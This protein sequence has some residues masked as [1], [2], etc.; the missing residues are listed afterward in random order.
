MWVRLAGGTNGGGVRGG[1][2]NSVTGPQF[3]SSDSHSLQ[4]SLE[5]QP[6]LLTPDKGH[7][8]T[9]LG[10]HLVTGLLCH[11]PPPRPHG[12]L[13]DTHTHTLTRS[14]IEDTSVT[15]TPLPFLHNLQ[16]AQ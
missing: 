7:E 8:F 2:V 10:Y 3:M 5:T 14:L 11:P 15:Q 13:S 16:T 1:G 4:S 9:S 12:K 6:S